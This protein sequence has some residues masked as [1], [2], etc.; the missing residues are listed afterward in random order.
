[1]PPHTAKAALL[2]QFGS[3]AHTGHQLPKSLVKAQQQQQ[4][5]RTCSSRLSGLPRH[6]HQRAMR[7]PTYLRALGGAA[8]VAVPLMFSVTTS[9][10]STASSGTSTPPS[11]SPGKAA[12]QSGTSIS[13]DAQSAHLDSKAQLLLTQ[14][15][16]RCVFAI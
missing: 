8:A 4:R 1:M 16:F 5:Q 11:N 12:A 2:R 3:P 15:V 10:A 13:P 14:V 9:T 7:T 6:H